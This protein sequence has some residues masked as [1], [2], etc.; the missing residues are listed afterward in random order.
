MSDT[1]T[2][3]VGLRRKAANRTEPWYLASSP[4]SPPQLRLPARRGGASST[5]AG[6][7]GLQLPWY[8]TSSQ[9]PP[10]PH[11][12]YIPA[13]KK[14]RLDRIIQSRVPAALTRDVI[15]LCS[16]SD[17]EKPK[18]KEDSSSIHAIAD[19]IIISSLLGKKRTPIATSTNEPATKKVSPDAAVAL[20]P[21]P[22]VDDVSV[23]DNANDANADSVA[24][25]QS[26]PRATGIFSRWTPQEDATLT[27]AVTNTHK[28]KYGNG[29]R[30]HWDAVAALVTGRTRKQC[31]NRWYAFL[32]PSIV[33]ATGR[34]G[35]WAEDEDIKLKE[36]V[37][38]NGDQ[39]WAAIAALV[40]GRTGKQCRMRWYNAFDPSISRA[41][42]HPGKW[43][44]DE[45]LKLR[46]AVQLHGSKDWD[47]IA[48]LVPGRTKVQCTTRWHVFLK[49][50][51]DRASG[52]KGRWTA[53]ED[54]TLN[55]AV[56]THGG[57]NWDAIAA[58]MPD[59]T[60]VQCW[61]RWN[62]ASK[63]SIDRANGRTGKWTPDEDDKLKDAV[64]MHDGKDWAA[65]SALVPSRTKIQCRAR[66]MNYLDPNRSTVK[67]GPS[68]E[69]EHNTLNKAPALG[70]DRP[71]C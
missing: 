35:N 66:W 15:D 71:F 50:S 42:G 65:I 33:R 69:E 14:P 32:D 11:D 68:R 9:P 48:V 53:V 36:S 3:T 8:L 54:D 61:S 5:T 1:G 60:R 62:Y 56:E 25:T 39:S 7:S 45:D 70:Q 49:S 41:T 4:S 6:E 19:T 17:D 51:I 40:P 47:A 31:V 21:P 58:L 18:A 27:S 16:D 24:D 10:P 67:E 64:Q 2:N 52:R 37:R 29:Y 12:E 22:D 59:R 13:T 57:K 63:P 28:K 55:D 20:P 26:N 34:S 23:D 46:H 43:S 30:V 38:L 44:E